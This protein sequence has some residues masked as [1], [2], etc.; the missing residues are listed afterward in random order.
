MVVGLR[1]C[2]LQQTMVFKKINMTKMFALTKRMFVLIK[3]T[4]H[5]RHMGIL[6]IF[7]TKVNI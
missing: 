2:T 7:Y 4:W 5:E 3:S 1:Y 6:I